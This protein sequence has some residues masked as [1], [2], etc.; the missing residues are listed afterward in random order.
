MRSKS[1]SVMP[2]QVRV[3]SALLTENRNIRLF[4]DIMYANRI[5]FLHIMSEG[6]KFRT[7][8]HMEAMRKN[9]L[10]QAAQEVLRVCE[11]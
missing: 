8:L 4:I 1:K 6:L 9:S 3:P 5:P 10:A 11:K 7:S 2:T